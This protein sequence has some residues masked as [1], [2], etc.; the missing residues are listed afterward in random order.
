M[1]FMFYDD[2]FHPDSLGMFRSFQR[3]NARQN[4]AANPGARLLARLDSDSRAYL[5]RAKQISVEQQSKTTSAEHMFAAMLENPNAQIKAIL[6]SLEIR[7]T[8]IFEYVQA[9]LPNLSQ[10]AD[11][12]TIQLSADLSQLFSLCL[13]QSNRVVAAEL[14]MHLCHLEHPIIQDV[15]KKFN[16]AQDPGAAPGSELSEFGVD[17]SLKAQEGKIDPIIGRA[18]EIKRVA[19]ILSRKT[20]NNPLLLGE[21][22]VGKT[23]IA[24]GLALLIHEGKAPAN[25]KDKKVF[26]LDLSSL[27]AGTK[28][29]GAFEE[30]IKKL[31]Q[32]LKAAKGEIIVFID[33]IHTIVGAGATEGQMDVANLLKPALARGDFAVIGATTLKEYKKYIAKDAALQRR[34]QTVAVLEPSQAE[35]VLICQ[36]LKSSYEDFH[37]VQIT[38]E[39]LKEAVQLSDRYIQDRFMPDKALDVLDEACARKSLSVQKKV[40][41]ADLES[42]LEKAVAK[43]DYKQ[44]AKIKQSLAKA[45]E[46]SQ[47]A[48]VDMEDIRMVVSEMSQVPL[49]KLS[50]D[51]SAKLVNLEETLSKRLIGQQQAVNLIADCIRRS[52]AG[53]NDPEAPIGNFLFLGPTGVGKTELC[54]ALAETMF[55]SSSQLIRLDMSEYM[56]S[57]SVA[58]L[59]GSPPGYVGFEDGGNLT[60][61]VAASPYSIVLL[62]EIEKAHPQVLNILLQVMDDGRL[63]DSH[64]KTV[65]FK[66][67]IIIASSN[68]GAQAILEASPD[69]MQEVQVTVENQL[70]QSFAPELINRFDEV[71]FFEKLTLPQ[72][73]QITKLELQKLEQKLQQ[74]QISFQISDAARKHLA[75]LGFDPKFGARPLKR[76]IKRELESKI[77]TVLL[78]NPATKSL[79]VKLLKNKTFQILS[80]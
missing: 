4:L 12:A 54:K 29:R 26:A 44:A 47:G 18:D 66:N 65:S 61:R 69:N 56:E 21:P 67:C 79:R 39:A 17:L 10:A 41:T 43:E 64:G 6:D 27:V 34:F 50:Q 40:D 16:K 37:K 1:F 8:E 72:V 73:Q 49:A 52:K 78:E 75:K 23:A 19:S 11:S 80:K 30:R 32:A 24:E 55:D 14:F 76:T 63:T 60:E 5:N 48:L 59:I 57:H 51:D 62:D 31:L 13:G 2:F 77:A 33:E 7:S 3:P 25:I 28:F 74:K 71:I 9:N 58:K 38:E 35:T 53:L 42:Q 45:E 36:G 68:I 70:L 15:L 20:K 46:A 22:G